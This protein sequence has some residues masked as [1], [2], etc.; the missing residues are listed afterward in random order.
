MAKRLCAFAFTFMLAAGLA[1]AVPVRAAEPIVLDGVIEASMSIDIGSG[2]PGVLESVNVEWG[3]R[4]T[5]GQVV[6]TLQSGVEKSTLKLAR[7]RASIDS[8]IKLSEARLKYAKREWER[9]NELY[10]EKVV[11]FSK[12]DETLVNRVM[13]EITLKEAEENRRL[14]QLEVKRSEEILK[15]MTIRSPIKGVVEERLMAKGEYVDDQPIV[16]LVQIDPLYV[17]V[18]APVSVYGSIHQGMRAEVTPEEPVG[19]LYPARVTVVDRVV[20]AASGTFRVRLEL[21]NKDD[22]LPA[23]LKCQVSFVG[24]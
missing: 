19:G 6:A 4:V 7:Y 23:G 3:D 15:R 22:K 18:I 9:A 10:N 13:A 12:M 24:E 2:V 17:E 11:P 21:P 5:I 8:P 20:D 16:R 14:A 1:G